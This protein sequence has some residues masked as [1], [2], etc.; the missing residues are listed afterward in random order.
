MHVV[1]SDVDFPGIRMGVQ[2]L[3]GRNSRTEAE[4]DDI[5]NTMN[6][7]LYITVLV[8]TYWFGFYLSML[9]Y[10]HFWTPKLVQSRIIR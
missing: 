3:R 10:R 5:T 2:T 4:A 6:T 1:Y 8:F 9:Q 7:P